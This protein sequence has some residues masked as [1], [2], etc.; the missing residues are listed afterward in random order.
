MKL[1]VISHQIKIPYETESVMSLFE[2]GLEIFHVHKPNFSETGIQNYLKQFPEKY[3]SKIF[4]HSDFPKFHSLE[5]LNISPLEGGSWGGAEYAFLSPIFDSI[6]KPGYKSNFDLQEVKENVKGK[7]I[8]ALGGIDENKIELCSELGFAGVAVCGALWQ[9]KN[10]IEK[11]QQ[12]QKQI[13]NTEQGTPNDE[14]EI[15]RH[16]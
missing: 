5:E 6:S 15:L 8:I 1:I 13:M 2:N 9:S 16:S 3:Q 12:I 11:F 4:R 14:V 7:N 10:P